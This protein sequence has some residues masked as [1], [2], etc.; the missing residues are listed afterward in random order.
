MIK[1]FM[2]GPEYAKKLAIEIDNFFWD[3]FVLSIGS[4]YSTCS[5]LTTDESLLEPLWDST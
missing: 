4:L 1:L 5:E 2:Y 3:D